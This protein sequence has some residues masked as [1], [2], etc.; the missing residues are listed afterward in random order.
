MLPWSQKFF[1]FFHRISWSCK[2][3][4]KGR[5][6]VAK[7][8]ERKTSGYFGLE[9]HFHADA[10]VRIDPRARIGWYFYKHAN[11]YDWS[12]WLAIARG[13]W[14]YLLL[15][16]LC[17]YHYQRNTAVLSLP[18][19]LRFACVLHWFCLGQCLPRNLTSVLKERFP[20]IE[21]LNEHQ[22]LSPSHKSI[23]KMCS[24]FCQPDIESKL[25]IIRLIPVG[26]Y[27]TWPA[28]RTLTVS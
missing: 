20:E 15:H 17:A 8:R 24:P 16:L 12:V 9:S 10:R 25:I 18:K 2:R 23:A 28:I 19:P 1:L 11:K 21:S 13:R 27:R 5:P 14:G 3:A 7:Q 6:R 22:S 4:T 26:K